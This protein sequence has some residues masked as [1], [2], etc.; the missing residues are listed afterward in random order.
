MRKSGLTRG[1]P[2]LVILCLRKG[3]SLRKIKFLQKGNGSPYIGL[4]RC[5]YFGISDVGLQEW[6]VGMTRV[7]EQKHQDAYDSVEDDKYRIATAEQALCACYMND[8]IHPSQLPL[9][10]AGYSSCFRKEAGSHGRD[11]SGIFRVLEFEMNSFLTLPYRV[12]AIVSGALPQQ[13]TSMIRKHGSLHLRLTES[14]QKEMSK[15]KRSSDPIT[16]DGPEKEA[17]NIGLGLSLPDWPLDE[18]PF[19]SCPDPTTH[20]A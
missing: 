2:N 3:V 7:Q 18:S 8:W 1:S 9:R 16:M 19:T 10:Y 5:A 11:T 13:Q 14:C 4:G 12:V 20:L 15:D 17:P 6:I